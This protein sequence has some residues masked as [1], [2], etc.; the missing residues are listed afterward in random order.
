MK[1]DEN[2]DYYYYYRNGIYSKI[3]FKENC[4]LIGFQKIKIEI[5]NIEQEENNIAKKR[6]TMD[7]PSE[8]RLFNVLLSMKQ[9]L[10]VLNQQ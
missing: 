6:K 3:K 5:L 1:W 7:D 9:T 8:K 4:I 10:E 2:N